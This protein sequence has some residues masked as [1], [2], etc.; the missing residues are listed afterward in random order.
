MLEFVRLIKEWRDSRYLQHVHI[1]AC[2][3]L[4]GVTTDDKK[5]VK[6]IKDVM[7]TGYDKDV[8]T[9]GVDIAQ[10][11]GSQLMHALSA[12][13]ARLE[14]SAWKELD[15]EHLWAN[16]KTEL[17]EHVGQPARGNDAGFSEAQTC[18]AFKVI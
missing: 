17:Q 13:V 8:G 5:R 7:I 6:S 1:E 15:S 18:A 10:R 14:P 3:A 2:S 4:Q 11:F 12:I 9:D 16:V